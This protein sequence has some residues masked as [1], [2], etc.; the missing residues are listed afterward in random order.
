MKQQRKNAI[1]V[2]LSSLVLLLS[3]EANA[4]YIYEANQDLY[5]LQTNANA[6]NGELAYEVSDD[7]VSPTI[8]LSFTFDY[9]G[10]AFTQARM[11]TNGCLHFKTSGAYCSDFTPDPLANQY[12][13]TLLPFWTDLIRDSGSRM[14]SYGDSSK[15]IFGWYD[16]REFNRASDNSFEI[17]LWANDSFEFRYGALDI[18]NHDVIIGEVGSGSKQV[19]QYLFHD[20][21]NTGSTNASNCVST[22]WNNTDKNSN[23]ENGGSLYGVG[24]G[25]AIDCSNPINNSSCSGY[26]A[27]YLT[28]E[29]NI[30]QLYSVDCP[31]YWEAYDDQQCDEDPQYSPGCPGYRQE[32]SVAYFIEEEFDYGFQDT[33]TADC[34]SNPSFCFDNNYSVDEI[35]TETFEQEDP[36]YNGWIDE[37]EMWL[38]PQQDFLPSLFEIAEPFSPNNEDLISHFE[39]EELIE[40]F[41]YEEETFIETFTNITDLEEWFEEETQGQEEHQQEEFVEIDEPEEEFIEEIFAEEV[42]EDI[43]E[44]I[45]ERIA[46]AVIEERIEREELE[47]A[48]EEIIEEEI[49]QERITN[50]STVRIS[51]IDV[52][53]QTMNVARNSNSSSNQSIGSNGSDNASVGSMST[54]SSPS[55]SDQVLSSN[56]QAQMVLNTNSNTSQ[57]N[58]NIIITPITSLDGSQSVMADVQI[59]IQGQIDTA[60][61]NVMTTSDSDIVAEKIIAQN[62]QTQQEQNEQEQSETGEYSDQ[63]TLIAYLGFVPGFDAYRIATVPNNVSWYEPTTIYGSNVIQDNT[64]AFYA[65]A[66]TSINKLST[67]IEQQPNL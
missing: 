35:Y 15:M 47:E 37:E 46:D 8:D 27:A 54:S 38:D 18:I 31:T 36:V 7:G 26:A 4:T 66:S 14:K 10:E 11:A 53:S 67:M 63:S 51:A 34:F 55:I 42:V 33:N 17:I 6:Y 64:E 65:M 28:Q 2:F 57:N 30:T 62:I 56:A 32:A 19:Y 12:T 58:A 13:Y 40:D 50:T 59:E 49:A 24:T 60:M 43:F 61:S 29:C 3:V 39:F 22:D 41:L 9:Y 1:A 16:M 5:Q 20:E 23:L 45:E 52:V 44:D 21:C 25:N 48:R